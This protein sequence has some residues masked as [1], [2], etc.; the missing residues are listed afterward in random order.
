MARAP[1]R[2]LEGPAGAAAN[3]TQGPSAA[4]FSCLEGHRMRSWRCRGDQLL[5]QEGTALTP[6]P[7]PGLETK[8]ETLWAEVQPASRTQWAVTT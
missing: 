1:L 8:G 2:Q 3:V 6:R 5:E 7:V 4:G